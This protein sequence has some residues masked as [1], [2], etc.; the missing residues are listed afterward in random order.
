M[1][2]GIALTEFDFH[3]YINQYKGSSNSFVLL[4]FLNKKLFWSINK[5]LI[6]YSVHAVL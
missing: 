4:E 3:G 1:Q 2:I 5:K 6:N